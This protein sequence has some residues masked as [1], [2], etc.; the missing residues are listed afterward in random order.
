MFIRTEMSRFA[1]PKLAKSMCALVLAAAALSGCVIDGPPP[2]G[3][4]G[5]VAS[6]PAFA[7]GSWADASG[8]ATA[9]LTSGSFVSTANDTGNRLAEGSY[10]YTGSNSLSLNYFSLVRQSTIRANCILANASTLNC[11]NDGGQQFQLFRRA[12]V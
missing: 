8:V 9:T 4:G 10:V 5:N 12:G 2:G 3:A 6:R 11:T 1:G 7:D